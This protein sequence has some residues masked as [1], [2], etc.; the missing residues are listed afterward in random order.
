MSLPLC[1]WSQ[2]SFFEI[3]TL[4]PLLFY[5]IRKN[6]FG[7]E[8]LEKRRA[9][10]PMRICFKIGSRSSLRNSIS[11]YLLCWH[12]SDMYRSYA[13]TNWKHLPGQLIPFLQVNSIPQIAFPCATLHSNRFRSPRN[14]IHTVINIDVEQSYCRSHVIL[15]SVWKELLQEN[16]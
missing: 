6:N 13:M 15:V 5:R 14:S 9:I 8:R 3:L 16:W 7:G 2:E 11:A 10:H 1:C 12:S 4:Y